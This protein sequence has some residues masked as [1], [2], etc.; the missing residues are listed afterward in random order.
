VRTHRELGDGEFLE[1]SKVVPL[2]RFMKVEE[3]LDAMID[4]LIKRL[5]FVRGL[6]SVSASSSEPQQPTC[7]PREDR[8]TAA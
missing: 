6:K 8:V 2:N 5:L 4:I 3:R 7:E 1:V